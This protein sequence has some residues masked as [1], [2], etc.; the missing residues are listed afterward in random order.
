MSMVEYEEFYFSPLTA[1]V[2]LGLLTGI[3][4]LA[5]IGLVNSLFWVL[6]FSAPGVTAGSYAAVWQASIGIV[7]AGSLFA[8]LTSVA[9]SGIASWIAI[10]VVLVGL[11]KPLLER[12]YG[13]QPGSYTHSLLI[14]I[15][16][17]VQLAVQLANS[18]GWW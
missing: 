7:A 17:A 8:T 3:G 12:I 10:P 4:G 9:M 1:S 18:T 16:N 2:L 15:H 5:T 13:V 6:G 14:Q 11:V